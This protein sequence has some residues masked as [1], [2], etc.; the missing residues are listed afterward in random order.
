MCG[1]NISIMEATINHV[2]K[3]SKKNPSKEKN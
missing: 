2:T 3:S 1:Y